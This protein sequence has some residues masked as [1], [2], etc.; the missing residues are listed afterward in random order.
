MVFGCKDIPGQV[1]VA[2]ILGLRKIINFLV[3]P[4]AL[5]NCRQCLGKLRVFAGDRCN[6]IADII[7][8]YLSR[9]NLLYDIEAVV[10]SIDFLAH[11]KVML[12]LSIAGI[13][14][15]LD[16][17]LDIGGDILCAVQQVHG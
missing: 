7:K 15:I 13:E 4:D 16:I 5:G 17:L 9:G 12:D 1:L 3:I 10:Y 14:L 2:F 6:R 11:F 8:V